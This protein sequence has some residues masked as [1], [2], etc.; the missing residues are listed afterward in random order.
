MSGTVSPAPR[1]YDVRHWND[2]QWDDPGIVYVAHPS[3]I[4]QDG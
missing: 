3:T 4:E 1:E 2:D